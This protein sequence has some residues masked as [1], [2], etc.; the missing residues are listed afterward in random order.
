MTS[1]EF[2]EERN[3]PVLRIHKL[4][5]SNRKDFVKEERTRIAI[6]PQVLQDMAQ[7]ASSP[8]DEDEAA[9]LKRMKDEQD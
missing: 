7:E 1:A 8:P 5:E 4:W 2:Q 9:F 6:L 3:F